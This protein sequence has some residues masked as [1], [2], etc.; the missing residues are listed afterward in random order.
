TGKPEFV[1]TYFEYLAQEVREYLAALGCRSLDEAIGHAELL[2]TSTA[3]AHWKAAGVDLSPLLHVPE[4]P[5]GAARHRIVGQDHALE[6]ALDNQLLTIADE[7]I[8]DGVPLRAQL[9]VRNV[10]RTVGTML[11]HE[12]TTRTGG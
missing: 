6:K 4:L 10:N 11:G 9:P 12:V 7:A 2:D 5:D 3:I 8:A 1:K